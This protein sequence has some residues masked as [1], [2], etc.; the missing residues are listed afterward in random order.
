MRIFLRIYIYFF[1]VININKYLL[2]I[3]LS[4]NILFF[5]FS[6][7]K[8]NYLTGNLYSLLIYFEIIYY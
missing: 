2:I 6:E 7:L 5:E 3:I 4:L 8:V 1:A